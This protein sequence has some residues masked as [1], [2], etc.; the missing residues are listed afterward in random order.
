M[1]HETKKG[2]DR[3]FD[4]TMGSYNVAEPCDLIGAHIKYLPE[5]TLQRV[6][7]GLNRDMDLKRFS[8][9]NRRT[10]YQFDCLEADCLD[11]TF[12]FKETPLVV[13]GLLK[14]LQV[15]K[16]FNNQNQ[17]MKKHWKNACIKHPCNTN[18]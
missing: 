4:V 2:H 14:T 12:K 13:K 7:M 17:I 5:K 16:Y 18:I 3:S 10:K 11:L 8:R 9:S 15:L 6:Q 1:S